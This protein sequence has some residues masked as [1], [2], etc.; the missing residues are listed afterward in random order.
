MP[1]FKLIR[2]ARAAEFA[3][4]FLFTSSG[5]FESIIST[6]IFV[7]GAKTL[8]VYPSRE[9]RDLNST[10]QTVHICIT[11]IAGLFSNKNLSELVTIEEFHP[12]G[13]IIAKTF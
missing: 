9:R 6:Q 1:G 12:D 11:F 2:F 4:N 13:L 10:T 5:C 8:R 3:N 7:G